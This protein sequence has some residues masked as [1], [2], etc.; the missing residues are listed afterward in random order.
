MLFRQKVFAI[1]VS[2]LVIVG[3][4]ELVRRRKLAEEYSFLWLVTGF[5]LLL[6]T[7]KLDVLIF[8]SRLI[9]A[10]VPTN[11]LFIFGLIFLM[12]LAL[13]FSLKF[14]QMASQIKNLAQEVALLQKKVEDQGQ[15]LSGDGAR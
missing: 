3:I 8:L 11:T 6:V 12:L 15:F 9:G 10:E 5:L 13:H 2:L 14:S 4:V 7:V 1:V